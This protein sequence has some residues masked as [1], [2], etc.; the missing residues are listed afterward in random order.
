MVSRTPF[1]VAAHA[2]AEMV[3]GHG[4]KCL[5]RVYDQ[6]K[7]E[8]QIRDTR[9]TGPARLCTIVGPTPASSATGGVVALRRNAR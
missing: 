3:L 1:E 8:P 2:L 4:Y 9:A 5:Q 7:Y 6:R